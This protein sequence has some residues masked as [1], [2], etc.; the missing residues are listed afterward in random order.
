MEVIVNTSADKKT[1]KI[2]QMSEYDIETSMDIPADHFNVKIENP[3]DENG[4]GVNAELFNPND[5]FRIEEAGITVLDG[6]ADDVDEYWDENGSK[7]EI[8]GRDKSMLLLENDAI[9]QEYNKI[10]ISALIKKIAGPFGFNNIVNPQHDKTLTKVVVE[11]GDSIWDV[12]FR[13]CN[14]QGLTIW[15]EPNGIINV[16]TPNYK[17]SPSYKFSN[18]PSIKNAIRIERFSKRKRGADIKNEVWVRGQGKKTFTAKATDPELTQQGYQRRL[19]T[20]SGEAQNIAEGERVAKRHIRDR[21]IG[22]FE[23][24]LTVHGR[25]DIKINKTAYVKDRVTRTEGTFFIVS[26]RSKKNN[27]VGNI[28]ILRLRRLDEGVQ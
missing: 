3:T 11:G 27:N 5:S 1:Y 19:I 23:I 8:D 24:E 2:R 10:K 4:H 18:D 7:V 17:E 15:C 20:E 9:P 22:T 13:E 21:K 16:D 28:K 12:I 26:V 25:H 6:L 14:K